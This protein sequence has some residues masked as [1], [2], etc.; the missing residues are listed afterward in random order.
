MAFKLTGEGKLAAPAD[1][2]GQSSQAGRSAQTSR[3]GGG[4]GPP[5]DAPDP[6]QK[7]RWWILGGIAAALVIGGIVVASR[8]QSAN[9]AAARALASGGLSAMEADDDSRSQLRSQSGQPG[10]RLNRQSRESQKNASREDL[11][12][13]WKA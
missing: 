12:N 7:Y 10:R 6:L 9:R 11:V 4:L 5:I 3:P 2:S 8:Q 13:C 1:D